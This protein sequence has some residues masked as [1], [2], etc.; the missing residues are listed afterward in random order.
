MKIDAKMAESIFSSIAYIDKIKLPNENCIFT[1]SRPYLKNKQFKTFKEATYYAIRKFY[2]S[3]KHRYIKITIV[4]TLID[5]LYDDGTN[6]IESEGFEVKE[7]MDITIPHARERDI[8]FSSDFEEVYSE[9]YSYRSCEVSVDYRLLYEPDSIPKPGIYMTDFG[10]YGPKLATLH[11]GKTDMYITN[12]VHITKSMIDNIH[13]TYAGCLMYGLYFLPQINYENGIVED[14]ADSIPEI[15]PIAS[16]RKYLAKRPTFEDFKRY[17]VTL[18][19][20][21]PIYESSKNFDWVVYIDHRKSDPDRLKNIAKLSIDN[22]CN[23]N[24]KLVPV[25]IEEI[26]DGEWVWEEG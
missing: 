25:R 10:Y 11:Y 14:W 13:H 1:I 17:K 7:F 8:L 19:P 22:I 3:Q 20:I 6:A 12:P 5:E 2:K 16:M 18:K 4:N 15:I 21:N 24:E 23:W 9:S 26:P